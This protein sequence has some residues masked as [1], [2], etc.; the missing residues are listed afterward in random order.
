M[1]EIV[2]RAISIRVKYVS[3]YC[4]GVRKMNV[5]SFGRNR[6][7]VLIIYGEYG[8]EDIRKT[9]RNLILPHN[10]DDKKLEPKRENHF[11]QKIIKSVVLW[12]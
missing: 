6:K 3:G 10:Y 8:V 9:S 4:G 12:F 7:V 1:K 2:K 11:N 5:S